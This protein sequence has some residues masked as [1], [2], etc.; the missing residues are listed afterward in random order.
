MNKF[1]NNSNQSH[2]FGFIPFSHSHEQFNNSLVKDVIINDDIINDVSINVIPSNEKQTIEIKLNKKTTCDYEFMVD[3]K[4][5]MP[6]ND[7]ELQVPYKICSFDIEASSSH[8]D[9]PIPIKTYKKLATN[10]MEYYEKEKM[11]TM[12]AENIQNITKQILLKAFGYE[13]QLSLDTIDLVYPKQRAILENIEKMNEK[14]NL[15]LN[16][17][18]DKIN[19]SNE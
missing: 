14:I 1:N 5:M 15:W 17:P 4:W 10:I 19:K 18:I 13:T 3:Q 11:D 2:R 6:L 12:S 9:F 7:K 8:G 16:T